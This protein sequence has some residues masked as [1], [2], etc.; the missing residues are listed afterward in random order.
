MIENFR[1]EAIWTAMMQ[2]DAIRRGLM[3]AGF[4]GLEPLSGEET[5]DGAFDLDVYP[6]PSSHTVHVD[7]SLVSS[8]R[9]EL[10]LYDLLGRRVAVLDAAYKSTGPHGL[11][12]DF[13]RLSSGTYFLVL[14]APSGMI[15]HPITLFR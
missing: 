15:T 7:F 4:S 6:N 8:G 14:K 3:K 12:A 2:H 1:T 5:P 9:I 13:S 10:A 11:A